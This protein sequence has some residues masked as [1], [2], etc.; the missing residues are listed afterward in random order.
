[1]HEEV[2]LNLHS[3][4][5]SSLRLSSVA[6]R[7]LPERMRST[8]FV[9]LGLT[10]AAGLALVA[11]FAQLGFP[12]LAPEP[13]PTAASERDAVAGAVALERG[14]KAIALGQAQDAVAAPDLS[15]GGEPSAPGRSQAGRAGVGTSPTPV[16]TSAPDGE[17]VASE[18]TEPASTPAAEPPASTSAQAPAPASSA[19][20]TTSTPP[21]P[22][23]APA[24]PPAPEA[25]PAGSKPSKPQAKPA[26]AK[27]PKPVKAKPPKPEADY[28]A[29]PAGA[30]K[31][32]KP[33]P[34]PAKPEP[35][36]AKP[37]PKPVKPEAKPAPEASSEPAPPPPP[38]PVDKGKE[39]EKSKGEK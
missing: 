16:S 38:P 13:L 8:A 19:V 36:P 24:A 1:M 17:P 9:F 28:P 10:A 3:K 35:K 33:E 26:K 6:G 29:K 21:E 27:P 23:P 15:G 37:E 2:R 30:N 18:P 12:L 39:Q 31:P 7:G 25:K 32:A 11:V 14:P 20:P 4:L 5:P 34:K 22:E